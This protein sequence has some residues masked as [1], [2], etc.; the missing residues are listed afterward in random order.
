MSGIPTRFAFYGSTNEAIPERN[1]LLKSDFFFP[2]EM[3][4]FEWPRKKLVRDPI[5]RLLVCPTDLDVPIPAD[6]QMRKLQESF[7]DRL[8]RLGIRGHWDDLP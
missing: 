8:D 5:T 4:G 3:C 7:Y 6:A 2:C 1:Q